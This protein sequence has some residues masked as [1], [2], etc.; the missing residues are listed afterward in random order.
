MFK[1]QKQ[2]LYRCENTTKQLK[3]IWVGVD[4]NWELTG[5]SEEIE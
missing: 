5:L 4:V 2:N 1:K 3:K